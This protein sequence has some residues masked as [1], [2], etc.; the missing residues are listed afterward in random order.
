MGTLA[1]QLSEHLPTLSDADMALNNLDRFFAAARNRLALAAFFE[2]DTEALPTLLQIFC[3]SQYLSDLLIRD[4]ESFDLLRLTE[5]QPVVR[6]VLVREICKDVEAVSD[7]R[8]V[9]AVLR[10]HKHR[11]TLRIAYGDIVRRQRLETVIEQISVLADAICEAARAGGEPQTGAAARR[12]AAARPATGAV[13]RDCDGQAGR[14]GIE[15][16]Q[17]HRLGLPVRRH[18]QNGRSSLRHQHRILR[19]AWLSKSSST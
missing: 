5:G 8:D 17:R 12:A 4:P 9:M 1:G 15:L 2:R 13:C 19:A 11:E 7:D 14:P 16:L 6:E 18:R 10:R 3:T